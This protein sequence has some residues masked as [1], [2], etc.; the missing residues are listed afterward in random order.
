[1]KNKV[2]RK[3]VEY[4][5]GNYVGNFLGFVVGT[6]STRLVAHFFTKRSIWNLWGTFGHK[7]AVTK[8]TYTKLEWTVSIV[9]G[10]IVFELVS[11]W[12]KKKVDQQLP[13]YKLTRWMV[14]K[15]E[16][17]KKPQPEPQ[18]ETAPAN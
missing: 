14:E 16:E 4:V 8:S 13:K 5:Y 12:L 7:T 15:N 17:E 6:A 9:I 2:L 3:F 10:F 1:M 18:A 11:K